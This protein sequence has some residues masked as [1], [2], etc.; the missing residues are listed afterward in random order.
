M[1]IAS[2]GP[3]DARLAA[4]RAA[5]PEQARA[6]AAKALEALFLSQLLAAM[7]RTV[8]ENDFLPRAPSRT[9]YEGMFDGAVADAIAERDPLGLVGTLGD[10]LKLRDDRADTAVG[11]RHDAAFRGARHEDR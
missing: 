10:R 4:L 11:N 9:A 6:T 5:P 7:R 8:P 1:T 3:D 2:V